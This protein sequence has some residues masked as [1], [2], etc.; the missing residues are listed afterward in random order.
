MPPV[1]PQQTEG[2]T[3]VTQVTEGVVM[4]PPIVSLAKEKALVPENE[5]AAEGVPVKEIEGQTVLP[6][7]QLLRKLKGHLLH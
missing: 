4:P 6:C 2:E 5:K 1:L 7:H 3:V